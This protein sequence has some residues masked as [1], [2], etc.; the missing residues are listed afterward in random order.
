MLEETSGSQTGGGAG[1]GGGKGRRGGTGRKK[2]PKYHPG[3]KPP[4]KSGRRQPLRIDKLLHDLY[5]TPT[6]ASSFGSPLRLYKAASKVNPLITLDEVKTWLSKQPAYTLHRDLRLRFPRR[7]V[8]VNGMRIQ[9]QADL[10]DCSDIRKENDSNR[11][12]LTVIDCF[13]RLATAIPLKSKHA[14][15]V[16]PA[17]KRAFKNLGGTPLKLQTDDG[18]EFKAHFTQDFLKKE[19]GMKN[20]F[21]T[22]QNVKAQIVERFNRTLRGKLQKYFAAAKTL[23]YIEVLPKLLEGYNNTIHSSLKKY[24]PAQVNAKNQD[25]VFELQYRKYLDEK[26][27]RRKFNIN[28]VVR[29]SAYR[30]TFF[31]KGTQNNFSAHLFVVTGFDDKTNPP[32]YRLKSWEDSEAIEGMFYESELQKVEEP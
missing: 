3:R 13:S 4:Q 27:K 30:A 24:S 8:I 10:M 23:R 32:T 9:Y 15:V 5:F 21:H 20:W 14:T 2:E 6:K 17:L 25:K 1:G 12:L 31:K 22:H 18:S 16:A 11:Y 7:K 28:D 29:V 19:L 26:K